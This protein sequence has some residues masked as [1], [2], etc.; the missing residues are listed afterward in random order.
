MHDVNQFVSNI[1]CTCHLVQMPPIT[2][3]FLNNSSIG[4]Q[5]GAFD[6]MDSMGFL[7]LVSNEIKELKPGM[8]RGLKAIRTIKLNGNIT[9]FFKGTCYT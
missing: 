6:T 3:T 5:S 7:Y 2:F 9:E 1:L 8:W 4:I